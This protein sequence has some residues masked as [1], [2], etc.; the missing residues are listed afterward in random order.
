MTR[1]DGSD[2]EARTS[3]IEEDPR[4]TT[5]PRPRRAFS[6][7]VYA[8]RGDHV[9][10]IEHRRLRTWLPIGGELEAGETPLEAARRELREE[11]GMVGRFRPLVDALDGVPPGL[12]G[13]EE[14]PAGSKGVHL[15]FVFV[16]EV[17]ADAE[18]VPNE[19]FGAWR[20][21]DLPALD[22]LVSPLNV[23]Q[24]GVLAL[25]ASFG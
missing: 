9:L 12:L 20:W 19:E 2:A 13:Y 14:H 16:A 24:F 23:R 22:Q 18:V 21:V 15:N 8:R 17:D 7:A 10:V 25:Q 6:V 1:R 3:S 5:E 4:G 11:T